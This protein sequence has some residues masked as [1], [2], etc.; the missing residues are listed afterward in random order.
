MMINAGLT[1]GVA[2]ITLEDA[3]GHT[4][5]VNITITPPVV[6]YIFI[7]TAMDGTTGPVSERTL[8]IEETVD[9]YSFGANR[10]VAGAGGAPMLI[11][12]TWGVTNS[13]GTV[14]PST[15][16]RTTFT[17]STPGTGAVTM[18]ATRTVTVV[19]DGA[20]VDGVYL[21]IIRN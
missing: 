16:T 11:E 14:D 9:L 4:A 20:P 19:E 17:G 8:A 1:G 5:A 21:P 6:D 15:G 2:V 12:V 7:S 18:S 3:D 13:I 10:T